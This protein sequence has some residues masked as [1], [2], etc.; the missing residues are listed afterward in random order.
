MTLYGMTPWPWMTFS[1]KFTVGMGQQLRDA[2][3]RDVK[4][5]NMPVMH[6]K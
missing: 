5:Q 2:E 3:L 4:E 1:E 6:S